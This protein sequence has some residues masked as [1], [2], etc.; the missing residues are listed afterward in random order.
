MRDDVAAWAREG[1]GSVQACD[2]RRTL[3][4]VK[5]AARA[6]ARPSGKVSE[7]FQTDRERQGAYDLLEGG[8][9]RVEAVVSAL[10]NASALRASAESFAYVAVDGASITLTDRRQAKDF[11]RVGSWEGHRGLKVINALG[12]SPKGVP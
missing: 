4:L 9:V 8:K 3:R 2:R 7:V 1:F 6:G 12:L 11:G 10:G 5:M